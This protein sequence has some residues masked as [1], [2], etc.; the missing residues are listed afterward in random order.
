MSILSEKNSAYINR[1]E[2][3]R[4]LG[5]G[6][7]KAEGTIEKILSE[8]EIQIAQAAN[9]KYVYRKFSR[10]ECPVALR[11]KAINSH[12]EGCTEIIL[13][14]AT[15]GT[16]IDRIIR[17]SS[18]TDMT[19][20]LVL[21]ACAG[22]FIEQFCIR[23]DSEIASE[24]PEKY[25]TWRFAPGYDDFPLDA[26]E[27]LLKALDANRKIGLSVSDSLILTPLK[28]I[29]AVIGVSENPIEN[30]RRGCAVCSMRES[31]KFRKAGSHCGF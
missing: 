3:L 25:L 18:V 6:E 31:C 22:A 30:K 17:L 16:E 8:C 4:Y 15:L 20:A 21:D 5:Y 2:E 13:F 28:S 19:R 24:F 1:S 27:S 26:Q 9:P 10:E 7:N 12:I 23:A 11:G 29:T 14:A